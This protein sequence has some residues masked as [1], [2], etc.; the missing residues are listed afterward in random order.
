MINNSL[1]TS[2]KKRQRNDSTC[3]TIH[4]NN[5]NNPISSSSS[6]SDDTIDLLLRNIHPSNYVKAAF[7]TNAGM[8]KEEHF[9]SI[10][11]I[12]ERRFL[13]TPTPE[14]LEAYGME[15]LTAV[16]N[17]DLETVKRLFEEEGNVFK[18]GVN[19]CNRF[20]ESILHIACRRGHLPM[21][22]FLVV[23]VGLQI[24]TIRDDYHRTP[25]HDAFWTSK[26]SYDVVDFL[27]KQPNAMELLLLKD[28][29]GF[30]PLDY[31][32]GEDHERWLRF[33]WERKSQ[34]KPSACTIAKAFSVVG[35]GGDSISIAPAT[36]AL[37]EQQQ[38]QQQRCESPSESL[39]KRQRMVVG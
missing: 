32:H 2:G 30:T 27:L 20:G 17:N 39:L 22:Q 12:C 3:D 34:L 10:T 11:K 14:M 21:V 24:T 25:L 5:N 16:R 7:K 28:K 4:N 19:A 37:D 38:Q 6:L 29:R 1:L 18:S 23:N 8:L 15:L 13:E 35:G 31:S 9:D 36:S 26:A 33:L